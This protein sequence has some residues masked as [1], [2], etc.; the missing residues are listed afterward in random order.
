M[1]KDNPALENKRAL[2]TDDTTTM[3]YLGFIE[4]KIIDVF[5]ENVDG[6][7]P[8]LFVGRR[9]LVARVKISSCSGRPIT[10]YGDIRGWTTNEKRSSKFQ[11]HRRW[12]KKITMNIPYTLVF[13]RLKTTI[14]G[15]GR[16]TC[17]EWPSSLS[18]RK[19]AR[20][21]ARRTRMPNTTRPARPRADVS[22]AFKT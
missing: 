2:R 6:F 12:R 4:D 16:N 15:R 10:V 18:R 14:R 19:N 17:N 21:T 20:G 11:R 8:P 22:C 9:A 3:F 5:Y 1:F 13:T 7:C